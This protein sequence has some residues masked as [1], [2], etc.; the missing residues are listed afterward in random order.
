MDGDLAIIHWNFK[1]WAFAIFLD[2]AYNLKT[3]YPCVKCGSSILNGSFKI[4]VFKTCSQDQCVAW[5]TIGS[6]CKNTARDCY[7]CH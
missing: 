2:Y 1:E 7:D 4:R 3:R 6:T 5:F